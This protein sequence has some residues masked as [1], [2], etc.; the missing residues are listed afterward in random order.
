MTQEKRLITD[1]LDKDINWMERL[2]RQIL[3]GT[4]DS[5]CLFCN[6]IINTQQ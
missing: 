5:I 4:D 2:D 6:I 1:S 3:C